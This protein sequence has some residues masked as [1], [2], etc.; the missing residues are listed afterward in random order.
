LNRAGIV[1]TLGIGPDTSE[2][3]GERMSF[4]YLRVEHAQAFRIGNLEA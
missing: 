1:P 4:F 3:S 2:K